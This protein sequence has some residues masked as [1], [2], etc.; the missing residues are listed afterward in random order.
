MA[1]PKTTPRTVD[2]PS[3]GE[4]TLQQ[5]LEAVADPVRRSMIAQLAVA[6]HDLSC[7]T[8]DLPVSRS[9]ATH[10][11]NVLREAGIIHQRYEG[12]TKIN[13]LRPDDLDT[14]FPGLLPAVIEACV[15]ESG[16]ATE[17][18]VRENGQATEMP[19]RENG[20]ATET[21]ARDDDQVS[22]AR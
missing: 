12:T 19:V 17:A 20:Q 14:R 8:F 15:R 10:H 4:V 1:R 18:P 11:F 9:T 22:A 2:N 21:P 5:F 13:T 16:R 6:G 3:A 7:G